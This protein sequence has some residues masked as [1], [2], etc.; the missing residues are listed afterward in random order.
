MIDSWI[1]ELIG[2]AASILVAV[3]L[4]MSSILRLRIVNLIGAAAFSL[5]GVLIGSL[6]VAVVNVFI[7]FVN[8]Y[9]LRGMMQA[10][11][12]FKLLSV[13]ADDEYLR[14][15]LRF[16]SDDI[17][18]FLPESDAAG[19][20]LNLFILRDLV[21]AGVLIGRQRGSTLEVSLDYVIPR[22]RDF[23][24][25]RYLFDEQADI[26]RDRGIETVSTPSGS[27]K[28]QAY[29]ERMGFTQVDDSTHRLDL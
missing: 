14:Y 11:E 9:Y 12:Y 24:I 18:R 16:H 19:A 20:D 2:Y 10:N 22:F 6:P 25:G 3:S 29:L 17:R 23:K 4:M 21:P 13:E 28:H 15:F 5:Y 1:A 8:L 7:I 26:F 27:L